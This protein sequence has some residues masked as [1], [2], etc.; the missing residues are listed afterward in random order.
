MHC[1]MYAYTWI[2]YPIIILKLFTVSLSLLR[3]FVLLQ[4]NLTSCNIKCCI[5]ILKLVFTFA[6]NIR[7]IFLVYSFMFFATLFCRRT[8]LNA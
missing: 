7:T 2:Y 8:T 5:L 1:L 6:S 3:P 4:N